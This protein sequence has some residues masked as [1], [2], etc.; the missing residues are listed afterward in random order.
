MIRDT[1][2]SSHAHHC[3]I[4]GTRRGTLQEQADPM[5]SDGNKLLRRPAGRRARVHRGPR[6][7]GGEIDDN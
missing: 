3:T 2:S 7:D 1:M 5:L 6:V 4:E